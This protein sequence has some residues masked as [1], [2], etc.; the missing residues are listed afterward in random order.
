M[1]KL[2]LSD[3]STATLQSKVF[4]A[5]E[6]AILQG[7]LN[8]GEGIT[9]LGLSSE[10]GVSR[11]PVR[12]A[13][14]QLELEGLVKL[15][16][17]KGAVVIGV[18]EKDIED[19]YIIRA[20]IEDLAV[21]WAARALTDEDLKDLSDSVELQEFYAKRGDT[22][23]LCELDGR[24][25]KAIYRFSRSTPLDRILSGFHHYILHARSM[26]F[27]ASGRAVVAV[28]EHSAIV[29]ALQKHDEDL[30]AK[31]MVE[32]IEKAKQNLLEVLV[33]RKDLKQ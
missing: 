21:R 13:F 7:E 8:S 17:N 12:E 26:S 20:R 11:T 18:T 24:F 25:H 27:S 22:D 10:L 4:E 9:E 30:A 5:I 1:E 31:L 23:K 6:N 19:I 14:Y 29:K 28:K 32:H 33:Q 2:S 3:N 16:P 15:I